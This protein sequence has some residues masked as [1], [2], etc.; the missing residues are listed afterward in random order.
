MKQY[1]KPEIKISMFS[2]E[3]VSTVENSTDL[4][5][6]QYGDAIDDFIQNGPSNSVKRNYSFDEA[7]SFN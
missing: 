2:A 7:I 1:I 5:S 6:A 3:T 4:L